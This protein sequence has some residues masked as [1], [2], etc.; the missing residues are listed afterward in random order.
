MKEKVKKEMEQRELLAARMKKQHY[1]LA[2]SQKM[3]SFAVSKHQ[4]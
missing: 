1:N 4:F 2:E 3:C